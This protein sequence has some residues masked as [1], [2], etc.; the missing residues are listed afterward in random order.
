MTEY[1]AVISGIRPDTKYQTRTDNP[2]KGKCSACQFMNQSSFNFLTKLFKVTVTKADDKRN[3]PIVTAECPPQLK[4]FRHS[5]LSERKK[6]P[7]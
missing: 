2:A 6:I 4:S 3:I 5:S 1:P 7:C